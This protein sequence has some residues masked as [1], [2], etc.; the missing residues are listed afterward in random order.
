PTTPVS[1]VCRRLDGIPLAIELA[2]ARVKILSVEQI[3]RRLRNT[4]GVLGGGDHELHR[5]RALRATLDWSYR[6]LDPPAQT[7][8]QRLSVFVGGATIDALESVFDDPEFLLDTLA[9]LVAPSLVQVGE[10]AGGMRY[11]LL[12][13]IRRYAEQHLGGAGLDAAVRQR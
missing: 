5:H 8:L 6:L 12:E 7:L 2:A 11:R 13:P 4:F 9:Q 1:D 10:D 3:A